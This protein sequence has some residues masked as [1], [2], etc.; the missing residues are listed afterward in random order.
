MSYTNKVRN[1]VDHGEIILV[2]FKDIP[3]VVTDVFNAIFPLVRDGTMLFA[4][5]AY[6]LIGPRLLGLKT[7]EDSWVFF[8]LWDPGALPGGR[9]YLHEVAV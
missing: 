4:L 6:Q 8:E 3:H 7:Q 9:I 5:F 1:S 2:L